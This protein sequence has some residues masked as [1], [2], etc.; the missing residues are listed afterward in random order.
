MAKSWNYRSQDREWVEARR[1][2]RLEAREHQEEERLTEAAIQERLRAHPRKAR[3]DE[4]R[5]R[6]RSTELIEHLER[7]APRLIKADFIDRIVVIDRLRQRY[8]WSRSLT[9]W[10]PKGRSVT[11][12]WHD[13]VNHL[14]IPYPIPPFLRCALL[15]GSK[16]W[17]KLAI[18]VGRGGSLHRA[19]RAGEFAFLPV[20]TKRTIHA[21]LQSRVEHGPWEALRR[22]QLEL[23]GGNEALIRNVLDSDLCGRFRDETRGERALKWLVEFD[24]SISRWQTRPL[25]DYFA[26]QLREEIV[27]D[28][29]ACGLR[30][31]L[32]RMQEWHAEL[33]KLR[34]VEH[35]VFQKS[36]IFGRTMNVK[37]EQGHTSRWEMRE[38]LTAKDL[39]REGGA[40]GHCVFSYR[41][42]IRR[43][44]SSIW[45]LRR[46]GERALTIEVAGRDVVQ[47]RGRAN[48][49]PKSE[50]RMV[51][52]E[53]A[54]AARVRVVRA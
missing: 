24:G 23:L 21:L 52:A 54:S 35:E 46:D 45:S 41:D 50:E 7:C 34:T 40:M 6:V 36:G 4:L 28:P 32:R 20:L 12:Q 13:L 43:G 37:D 49:P 17:G 8:D 53:W 26:A 9:D 29:F 2:A 42:A 1:C 44:R 11:R 51:V 19:R 10:R 16:R 5:Q 33:A 14:L 3:L 22:V 39:I 30:T 47:M 48:R 27:V 38:I 18:F 15:S 25:I 31:M